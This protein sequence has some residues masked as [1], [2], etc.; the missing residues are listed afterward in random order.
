[1]LKMCFPIRSASYVCDDIVD[2]SVTRGKTSQHL[3]VRCVDDG[4]TP[5]GRNIALPKDKPVVPG[6]ER[7]AVCVHNALSFRHFFQKGVQ[8]PLVILR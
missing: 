5:Q 1:M 6:A 3:A 2:A 4:V 7:Q 8:E